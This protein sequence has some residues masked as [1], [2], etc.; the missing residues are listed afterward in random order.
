MKGHRVPCGR[1]L[2]LARPLLY[3]LP[4]GSGTLYRFLG[5]R[6]SHHAWRDRGLR[7]TR[8]KDHGQVMR[9]DLANPFE[10]E[11]YY[12]GRF[13]EWELLAVLD[14]LLRPGDT[15]IDVGANIGMITLHAA[16][17][18]GPQGTVLAFEPNPEAK[19][20]LDEH[21]QINRLR[22]VR[23]FGLAL[24]D[25]P[26]CATLSV[27]TACSSQSTLRKADGMASRFEVR[28][29]TLDSFLDQIPADRPV[30]LKTDTEG[31]DFNVL[32]GARGLL[33]RPAVIA[34][35]E[36]NHKWLEQL[37]RAPGR[38]S[39]T[40]PITASSRFIPDC[41]ARV[42]GDACT[43]SRSCS[44][45]RITGSTLCSCAR[46]LISDLRPLISDP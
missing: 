23:T 36:V 28:V 45:G 35:S 1:I 38:C 46:L 6:S 25:R 26:G 31:Y 18:V 30:F 17:K 5:G 7:L 20:R 27:P 10:R 33:S 42:C 41:S 13:Y 14:H 37:A 9:L 19:A 16:A 44:P 24:G 12:L 2:D 43:L 34:F 39:I 11:T 29:A 15:F 21:I 4:C 3:V 22:N 8:G 40:W 32:K